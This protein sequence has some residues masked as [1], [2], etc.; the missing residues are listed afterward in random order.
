MSS[1]AF[2]DA[3]GDAELAKVDAAIHGLKS[4]SLEVEATTQETGKLAET[5]TAYNLKQKGAKTFVEILAPADMKG[6]KV[7]ILSADALYVFLPAFGKVRRIAARAKDESFLG[8]T[9]TIDDL[10]LSFGGRYTAT[11]KTSGDTI[12]L[13]LEPK[14]EP[15]LK[16]ELTANAKSHLPTALKLTGAKSTTRIVVKTTKVDEAISDDT[17]T[18]RNLGE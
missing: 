15:K 5:K 10:A 3:A 1:I 11:A 16:V 14:A 8:L 6:T 13:S 2:A 18:K 7:L 17:F 4:L 9:M 12:T